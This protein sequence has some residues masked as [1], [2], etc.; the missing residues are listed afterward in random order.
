[1]VQTMY[2]EPGLLLQNFPKFIFQKMK[3]HFMVWF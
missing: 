3:Q 1:M 2:Q